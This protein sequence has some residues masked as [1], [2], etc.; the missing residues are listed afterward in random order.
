[1]NDPF[2]NF[3]EAD[4]YELT[5]RVESP[6]L[7]GNEPSF[8]EFEKDLDDPRYIWI[9]VDHPIDGRVEA[10]FNKFTVLEA[11]RAFDR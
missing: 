5:A 9:A 4:N 11:L 6:P 8:V 7:E 2:Y 3:A 10:K 1:M